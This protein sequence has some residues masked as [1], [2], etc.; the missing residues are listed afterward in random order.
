MSAPTNI[1]LFNEHVSQ[2]FA[3]LYENFPTPIH[4]SADSFALAEADSDIVEEAFEP[5]AH[6][7]RWLMAE[8]Y[9]RCQ[10]QTLDDTFLFV[11]LTEKGLVTLNSIPGALEKKEPLGRQ[12]RAA[13]ANGTKSVARK[14]ADEAIAAGFKLAMQGSI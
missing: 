11:Q 14:L 1:D 13:V 6:T 4:L 9:I 7:I 10:D 2:T 12:L 5:V 3:L 8:G